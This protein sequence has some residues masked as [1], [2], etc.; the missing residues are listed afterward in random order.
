MALTIT[1][2]DDPSTDL[3]DIFLP[4]RPHPRQGFPQL[5]ARSLLEQKVLGYSAPPKTMK[6]KA[7]RCYLD[8]DR[9]SDKVPE[10]RTNLTTNKNDTLFMTWL[11]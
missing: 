3:A 11:G 9:V 1:D 6:A 10:A 4:R 8:I 2:D 7:A 5:D